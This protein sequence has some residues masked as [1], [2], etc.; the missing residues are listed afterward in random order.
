MASNDNFERQKQ[1]ADAFLASFNTILKVED[2]V[3]SLTSAALTYKEL[4]VINAV[5]AH[6]KLGIMARPT[7]LAKDL[8][9]TMSSLSASISVLEK[10]GYLSRIRDLTDRRAVFVA[11]TELGKE[12]YDRHAQ[13]QLELVNDLINFLSEEEAL[14]MQKTIARILLFI[15]SKHQTAPKAP[16]VQIITDSVSSIS[17][18]EAERLGVR[19][20]PIGI[21][22]NN[23]IVSQKE[24]TEHELYDELLNENQFPLTLHLTS[25]QLEQIYREERERNREVVSIHLSAEFSNTYESA[26][27]AAENVGG[28]YPVNSKNAIFG[29]SLLV[30][31]AAGL[32][33]AG[34]SAADIS[35][36]ITQLVKR[37]RLIGFSDAAERVLNKLN[38]KSPFFIGN[39]TGDAPAPFNFISILRVIDGDIVPVGISNNVDDA[40]NEIARIVNADKIDRR[41]PIIIGC[42]TLNKGYDTFKAALEPMLSGIDKLEYNTTNAL[43]TAQLGSAACGIA[44]IAEE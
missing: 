8:E 35:E 10:K 36:Q 21:V 9:V 13:F 43:I 38:P 5:S 3:L 16:P 24:T 2:K 44:Y 6:E 37:V 14:L 27:V 1:I 20:L 19:V 39:W 18:E 33:D 23:E 4:C 34:L 17:P 32:R 7:A 26:L 25:Y 31:I 40:C 28:I 11:T 42:T 22:H 30:R 41:Y 15:S 29:Q 12:A